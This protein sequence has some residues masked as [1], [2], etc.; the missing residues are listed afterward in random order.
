[1]TFRLDAQAIFKLTHWQTVSESVHVVYHDHTAVEYS[2][3]RFIECTKVNRI[4]VMR[5][6]ILFFVLALIGLASESHAQSLREAVRTGN[7]ERVKHLLETGADANVSDESG[8]TPIYFAEKLEVVELLLSH[9]AK[10]DIRPRVGNESPIE[11]AAALC[12]RDAKRRDEWKS[13][14]E[15][16]ELNIPLILP[17]T[18]MTLGSSGNN[19]QWMILG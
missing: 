2:H 18:W 4:A 15:K 19:W 14:V 13:I 8:S 17:S 10:L 5:C 7:V 12:Y 11:N 9:G 6:N 1:M 3:V 16:L